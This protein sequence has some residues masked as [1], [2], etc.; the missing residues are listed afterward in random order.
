MKIIIGGQRRILHTVL[1]LAT[2]IKFRPITSCWEILVEEELLNV[3]ESRVKNS[4][5]FFRRSK[6][7]G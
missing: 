5:Q 6:R 4:V 3:I 1:F 7:M 2:Y